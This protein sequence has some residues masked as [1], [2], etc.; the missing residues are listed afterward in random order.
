[1]VVLAFH[2]PAILILIDV[3]ADHIYLVAQYSVCIGLSAEQLMALIL[4]R[5]AR[6]EIKIVRVFL[7]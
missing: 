7:F 2:V 4:S 3:N 6:L 1:M 5:R